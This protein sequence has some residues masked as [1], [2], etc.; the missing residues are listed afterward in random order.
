MRRLSDNRKAKTATAALVA[1]AIILLTPAKV[2]AL[3][4][5][6]QTSVQ[7]GVPAAKAQQSA[8]Q[9]V[10]S[11]AQ[12]PVP[13][14]QIVVSLPDKQLALL[15]DG[16]VL[17]VYSVA[18]GAEVSHSPEGDFTIINRLENPTYYAP[19]K[20]IGPGKDNPVGTRWMGLSK[21]GYGIHGTNQPSSIGKAASHG[22]I[23]MRRRDLEELFTMVRVGDKVQL[24]DA[25]MTA[26]LAPIQ[27]PAADA[28]T[29]AAN[30]NVDTVVNATPAVVSADGSE[31]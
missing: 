24:R 29:L 4:T 7:P 3:Q 22:C 9:A 18:V 2:F 31:Q 13:Q 26:L 10:S 20:V 23:R 15:E 17:K 8:Q 21:K 28:P 12:G 6:L 25:Q 16:H 1:A 19:G 30:G 27:A 14:R 5:D 11:R